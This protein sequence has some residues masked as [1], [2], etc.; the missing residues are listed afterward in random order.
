MMLFH[1]LYVLCISLSTL[2]TTTFSIMLFSSPP[3]SSLLLWIS[4]KLCFFQSQQQPPPAPLSPAPPHRQQAPA[5]AAPAAPAPPT[6]CPAF[7]MTDIDHNLTS[8]ANASHG[9][10]SIWSVDLLFFE[11]SWVQAAPRLFPFYCPAY[12]FF[13]FC[14]ETLQRTNS[15]FLDGWRLSSQSCEAASAMLRCTYYNP[16]KVMTRGYLHAVGVTFC[17]VCVCVRVCVCVV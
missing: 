4:R 7:I 8:V 12:H 2:Q 13:F 15:F 5:P 17:S 6:S 10:S 1:P 3:S 11:A 9:C 16:N 14:L